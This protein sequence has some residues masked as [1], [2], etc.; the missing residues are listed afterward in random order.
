MRF[1]TE[2]ID[3]FGREITA[4][5]DYGLI[6]LVDIVVLAVAAVTV[7]TFQGAVK[8]K[9]DLRWFLGSFLF[10]GLTLGAIVVTWLMA[11]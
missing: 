4:D 1:V 11:I 2:P 5:D 6:L 3:L 7:R 10:G 9:P 8:R